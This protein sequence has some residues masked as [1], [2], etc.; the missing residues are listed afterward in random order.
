MLRWI[1]QRSLFRWLTK[2]DGLRWIAGKWHRLRRMMTSITSQEPGL[3]GSEWLRLVLVLVFGLAILM[4]LGASEDRGILA[5]A[6]ALSYCGSF[7]IATRK[8]WDWI[9]WVIL[10]VIV[11][12]IGLSLSW[13]FRDILHDEERDS[14]STTVRNLGLLIGGLVAILLAVWRSIV[15]ER[16]ADTAQQSLLN[17]RYQKGAEM[18]GNAVLSVRL[19]GIYA[20]QHLA[21]ED[22]GQYHIQV[23]KLLCGFIR[24]PPRDVNFPEQPEDAEEFVL[25]EDVQAA[26]RVIGARGDKHRRLAGW[27]AYH[28]DLHGA[29]LRGG[30]LTGLDLSTPSAKMPGP[31]PAHQA[32]TNA[33]LRTDLSGARL[34]EAKFLFTNISGVDFSRNGDSPA[35]GLT[36][37]QLRGAQWDDT[38]PPALKGLVDAVSSRALADELAR[39]R[40]ASEP[41]ESP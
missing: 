23:M 39:V 26:M 30:D 3:E 10:L 12:A 2:K 35:T 40:T 17:E 13:E 36:T 8:K 19:G 21:S 18:L 22:P 16:Q 41:G 32:F 33:T 31:M 29:D 38:N 37:S 24:Y 14:V 6:L 20:L 1:R 34:R 7:V 4:Y 27:G 15:A 9:L 25:R 5:I 28:I 11:V